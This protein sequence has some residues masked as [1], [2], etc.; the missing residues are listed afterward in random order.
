[1]VSPRSKGSTCIVMVVPL[2]KQ[3]HR[4]AKQAFAKEESDNKA[5]N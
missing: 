2:L 3:G 1:M 5:E 4:T